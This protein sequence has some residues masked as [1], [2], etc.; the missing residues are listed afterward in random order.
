MKIIISTLFVL[1]SL[2]SVTTETKAQIINTVAG[3]G[4]WGYA[5]DGGP[6]ISAE[7]YSPS[8][9]AVDDS[10]NFYIADMINDRIRK[11]NNTGTISTIAGNGYNAGASGGYTGGYSGDGGP[12]TAAELY[13]PSSIAIDATHNIYFTDA[14]NN[15]I[16]KI[17]PAG[18]ISTIA[19]TDTAGY[20]GDGGPA[21]AARLF[22]PQ[23]LTLDNKGNMFIADCF[24]NRIRKIDT[25]GIISTIAGNGYGSGSDSGGYSGDGGPADSAEL[26]WP[27]ALAVSP[28]GSVFIVDMNNNCIRKV[29]TSGIITT[30]AGNDT[31][32][33]YNGDGIMAD[34]A[35]LNSPDG[36]TLD[37]FGNI[38][39][40]DAGN[41][42]IRKIGLDNMITTYA[43]DGIGGFAGDGG[44]CSD[45]ELF[46]PAGIIFDN[47]G[48]MYIADQANYLIRF[49]SAAPTDIN[50]IPTPKEIDVYPN[51]AT[52]QITIQS[53]AQL[54]TQIIITNIL[55]Q[56]VYSKGYNANQIEVDITQ[57]P[58]GVYFV[59]I[60]GNEERKFIKE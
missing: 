41:D 6:A 54:I 45:A 28:S 3:N 29:D 16:R 12:A 31:I 8:A 33:G 58:S 25:A 53:T 11:V 51:P 22:Y 35:E 19:G 59:N 56:T 26:F 1:I 39:I 42:R 36:I 38:Y 5:G 18:I 50:K 47:S 2:L 44:L 13:W 17:T 46:S 55:G 4:S 24:N 57:L 10:G 9:V 34:S 14:G 49:I 48:N 21:S 43:G 20:S 27:F 15:C 60:N 52:T 7:L 40:A 32:P 30:I 23:G 37:T